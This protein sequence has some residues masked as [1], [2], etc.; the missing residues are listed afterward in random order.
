[1]TLALRMAALARAHVFPDRLKNAR[2]LIGE[3]EILAQARLAQ[4]A[5]SRLDVYGIGAALARE[6]PIPAI[7]LAGSLV[8]WFS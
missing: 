6:S 2:R 5:L 8:H 7:A 1:M 3:A 4:P